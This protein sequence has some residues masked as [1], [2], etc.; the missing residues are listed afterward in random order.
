ML[1]A[2]N[3]RKSRSARLPSLRLRF[4][5]VYRVSS[6]SSGIYYAPPRVVRITCRTKLE[7][8]DHVTS[9][10]QP[11]GAGRIDGVAF[12]DC[13]KRPARHSVLVV[14]VRRSLRWL[15]D[16]RLLLSHRCAP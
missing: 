15:R 5:V 1:N 14:V 4:R 3:S 2:P 11:L 13:Q 12:D 8:A 9:L 10:T 7:A 6:S 16:R